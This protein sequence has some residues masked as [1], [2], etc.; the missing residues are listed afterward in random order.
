MDLLY[1]GII[2]L[3]ILLIL[4]FIY[5]SAGYIRE[6][7]AR[8]TKEQKLF[9]LEFKK[10][11]KTATKSLKD[12]E[13]QEEYIN[14]LLKEYSSAG[15]FH[16]RLYYITNKCIGFSYTYKNINIKIDICTWDLDDDRNEII[17]NA[18]IGTF[19]D[20][21]F[22]GLEYINWDDSFFNIYYEGNFLVNNIR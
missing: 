1:Y 15:I 14:S 2:T 8:K 9:A 10:A 18:R 17:K 7:F 16:V 12:I 3:I 5:T 22:D 11:F 13:Y 6:I 20:I 19:H 4:F 21:Y